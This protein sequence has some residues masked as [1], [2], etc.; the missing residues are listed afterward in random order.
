MK[1]AKTRFTDEHGNLLYSSA[2]QV[3]TFDKR[4]PFGCERKFWFDVRGGFERGS[5]AALE[6]GTRI[7][8]GIEQYLH[9]GDPNVLASEAAVGK[10]LIDAPKNR[11]HR[12]A[13]E[14]WLPK[15]FTIAGLPIRGKMDFVGL[16][17]LGRIN[18]IVDWKTTSDISKYAKRDL[19]KDHQIRIYRAAAAWA[20]ATDRLRVSLVYFQTKGERKAESIETVFT[21]RHLEEELPDVEA[22]LLRMKQVALV[23][24]SD[25]VEPDFRKC[26][27]GY[28][29][30][31]RAVCRNARSFMSMFGEAK[32]AD[33]EKTDQKQDAGGPVEVQRG[34]DVE[35]KPGRKAVDPKVTEVTISHGLTI[36]KGNFNSV[37]LDCSMTA[38][39]GA[40]EDPEDVRELISDMVAQALVKEGERYK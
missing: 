16:D 5:D 20:G 12:Y 35:P 15:E 13:V 11:A 37:R 40:K 31:Y 21:N 14:Q 3:Q 18:E 25:D 38:K 32:V 28:G 2:T 22:L 17:P 24:D 23:E 19:L 27:I 1:P 34:G 6:R 7:H 39:V 10:H 29:C 8:A 30:P 36:N 4:T 9:H 33:A 26:D